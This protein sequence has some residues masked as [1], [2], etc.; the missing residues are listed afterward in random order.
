MKYVAAIVVLWALA[1]ISTLVIV[2]DRHV[3]TYLGPLYAVCMIG[4]VLVVRKA[5]LPPAKPAG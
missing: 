2:A 1:I 4:S 3:F 5:Q